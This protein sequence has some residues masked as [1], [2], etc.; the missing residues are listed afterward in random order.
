MGFWQTILSWFHPKPPRGDGW[1]AP[2]WPDLQHTLDNVHA[3]LTGPYGTSI[4]GLV[5]G[6]RIRVRDHYTLAGAYSPG[7]SGLVTLDASAATAHASAL[8][9]ELYQ[10]RLPDVLGKG[11]NLDHAPEWAENQNKLETGPPQK[12]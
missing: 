12:I 9:H 1:R 8:R 7:G 5:V 3:R 2:S 11:V 4:A 10:H 6:V